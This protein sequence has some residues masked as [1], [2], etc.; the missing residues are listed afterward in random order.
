[1]GRME[2]ESIPSLVREVG[3]APEIQPPSELKPDTLIGG[4][5]RIER[6][7][8]RGGMGVVWLARDE[9]LGRPVA[10][11]LHRTG[12]TRDD[13]EGRDRLLQEARVR[14]RL[15]HPHVVTVYEVGTFDDDVFLAMEYH[16][17]GTLLRWLSEGRG[18]REI[19]DRF[20]EAGCGLAAAHEA[21]LVHGDF[22]P[23]NV[24]LSD[25]GRARV[26]DFGL[27]RAS[28]DSQASSGAGTPDYMAPELAR[29]DAG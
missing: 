22:K 7:L 21:G 24:L 19:V 3:R 18:W 1:M 28:G 11:K 12:T 16:A 15:S 8:G 13:S 14:A 2:G 23:D 25:D 5:F 29:G 20:V 4:A 27:A 17:G 6:R 26:S 9:R 10:I